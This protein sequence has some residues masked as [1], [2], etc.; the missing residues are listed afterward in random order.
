[1][2]VAQAQLQRGWAWGLPAQALEELPGDGYAGARKDEELANREVGRESWGFGGCN[3]S[4]KVAG[5]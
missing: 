5:R 4:D 1:M 2:E 3:S